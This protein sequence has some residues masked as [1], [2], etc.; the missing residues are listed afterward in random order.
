MRI[1]TRFPHRNT[2]VC[3]GSALVLA[4]ISANSVLA[5]PTASH[6]PATGPTQA[7]LTLPDAVTPEHYDI[8]VTPDAKALTFTGSTTIV[9]R[10]HK[11]VRSITLNAAD[12][13]FGRVRLDQRTG[14]P[15]ISLDPVQQ[16]ARFTFAQPVAPGLHRL[17]IDYKGKIYQQASGLFALDYDTPHGKARALFTQFENSDARRFTPSFDEPGRK[18]SFTLTA[19]TP[20]D[21]MAISNMPIASTQALPGGLKRVRFAE[22]PKMSSYLL[23][24]GLGDFERV[25]RKVDGVDVGVVV[26]RGDL[27]QAR[28]ALD[29]ASQILPYYDSYFGTRFPL[30]K[31]DL[32][33]GPGSSQF[34][35]AME[36]WGAIFYFERDL[37]IDPRLATEDDRQNVYIVVAHEMAHQWFGDLVTMAWWD[38]LWLN[39]GFASWMENKVTDHFHPEWKVWLQQLNSKQRAMQVDAKDGTH[40]VI[41]PI[42]DVL[43]ASG[44][45]DDITYDKGASVIRMLE[46]YTGEDAWR[47]GIRQYIAHHAYGAAVTDDLWREIDAVSPRKVAG[48]AHDFT[49]QAGVPMVRVDEAG[50]AGERVP[51]ELKLA[52]DQYFGLPATPTARW[53]VPLKLSGPGYDR[54]LVL[55]APQTV[56]ANCPA[57]VNAGQTSYA[58]VLYQG[59]AAKALADLYPRLSPD[60]QLGV[61]NDASSEANAGYAPMADYLALSA[62]LP[63]GA[64]PVVWSTL[65]GQFAGLDRL[66]DGLPGQAQFRAYALS[67]LRPELERLGWDVKPGDP[68]NTAGERQVL[69]AAMGRMGDPQVVAEA[70]RRFDALMRGEPLDPAIRR[71]VL[72]IVGFNADA[73]TWERI[74]QLARKASTSLEKTEL[75]T[76]LGRAQDPALAQRALDLSVSGETE[77]TT[78]P[79]I[80]SAVSAAHPK[81]ALDFADTHWA[82]VEPLLDS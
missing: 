18:A 7:R 13:V 77:P 82:Q 5:A 41:T 8:A 52:P 16:T 2:L 74:H 46:S 14:A 51:G 60:D 64:D 38:D 48:I 71:A 68:V 67:R 33:G 55:D 47:A 22:T 50:C 81:L 10:A 70:H 65:A 53:R 63:A 66:Y 31:L 36:N 72:S 35:G 15:Q 42:D 25:S 1:R 9:V 12:I 11:T 23:F 43:Q 75:Y 34:F 27:A 80:I 19:V 26:K 56:R 57:I 59:P 37:L 4:G 61:V 39:E 21:R 79:G 78:A 62:K 30:P 24:F 76:L 44:A 49:L 45:F 17:H 40:P 29:A 73:A 32:I 69:L 54:A 20:A 6:T 58:R 3:V 28:F